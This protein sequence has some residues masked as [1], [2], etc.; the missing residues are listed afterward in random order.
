MGIL[1][2]HA[3][4]RVC[5]GASHLPH[6]PASSFIHHAN[7]SL[8]AC[9]NVSPGARAV[10]VAM[11]RFLDTSPPE[12]FVKTDERRQYCWK[13]VV[14]RTSVHQPDVMVFITARNSRTYSGGVEAMV[15]AVLTP[16]WTPDIDPELWASEVAR[17]KKLFSEPLP[18][19]TEPYAPMGTTKQT[20]TD[21][22]DPAKEFARSTVGVP[23][24]PVVTSVAQ[25]PTDARSPVKV[26]SLLLQVY[27]GPNSHPDEDTPVELLLGDR[28]MTEKLMGYKFR[29]SPQSFFQVNTLGAEVLYRKVCE[30]GVAMTAAVCNNHSLRCCM[31]RW[32]S[33]R[34]SSR[35]PTPLW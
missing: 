24:K 27:N 31:R 2:G 9:V 17:L 23:D 22:A 20:T 29:V 14:V 30:C 6:N 34:V 25:P 10:C 12:M 32:L 5:F 26:S 35:H 4:C 1:P 21:S 7:L 3:G 8:Q 13:Q 33:S 18:P 28:Y 19:C 11:Q 15:A 16:G